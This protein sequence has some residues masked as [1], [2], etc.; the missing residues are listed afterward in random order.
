MNC[1]VCGKEMEQGW[2]QGANFLGWNKKKLPA[3]VIG[4][5]AADMELGLSVPAYRCAAC[6]KLVVDY[7]ENK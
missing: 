2:L 5:M 6:K 1:P 7:A 4:M 3:L